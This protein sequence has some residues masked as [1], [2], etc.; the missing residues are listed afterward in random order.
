MASLDSGSAILAA[1]LGVEREPAAQT[2]SEVRLTPDL[3]EV[4]HELPTA[5]ERIR[6]ARAA[7]ERPTLEP[8]S[9]AAAPADL[10]TSLAGPARDH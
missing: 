2:L 1:R 9:E 3:V 7:H 4:S 6:A 5:S 8:L 10:E